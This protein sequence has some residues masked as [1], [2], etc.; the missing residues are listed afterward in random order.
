M[1]PILPQRFD[2]LAMSVGRASGVLHRRSLRGEHVHSR[3]LAMMCIIYHFS[4]DALPPSVVIHMQSAGSI[5]VPWSIPALGPLPSQPWFS[6][7]PYQT[8]QSIRAPQAFPTNMH[9]A[10]CAPAPEI[11]YPSITFSSLSYPESRPPV[12]RL[13]YRSSLDSLIGSRFAPSHAHAVATVHIHQ[14]PDTTLHPVKHKMKMSS[15]S[16]QP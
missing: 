4:I 5:Y 15:R 16:K 10:P 6:K 14:D 7:K 9:T 8:Q 11:L 13:L 1:I 3:I 2:F 12:S